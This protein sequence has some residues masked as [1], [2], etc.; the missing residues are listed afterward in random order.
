MFIVSCNLHTFLFSDKM[1]IKC[2][3][4]FTSFYINQEYQITEF[5]IRK[6]MPYVHITFSDWETILNTIWD[7]LNCN[8]KVNSLCLRSILKAS[9]F[10]DAIFPYV[11]VKDVYSPLWKLVTQAV[12]LDEHTV[13][14][15]W[16]TSSRFVECEFYPSLSL[17][18][19]GPPR[20]N[21]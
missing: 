10:L 19:Q 17:I 8:K 1:Y 4:N 21:C 7:K 11:F 9:Q 2:K 16:K 5:H 14:V 12:L 6:S 20:A 13:P 18:L 3:G 15:E